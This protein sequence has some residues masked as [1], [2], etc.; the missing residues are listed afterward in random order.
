MADDLKNTNNSQENESSAFHD[1]LENSPISS[2]NISEP[3]FSSFDID[4]AIANAR[5]AAKTPSSG[6]MARRSARPKVK[7]PQSKPATFDA[8]T[9]QET[10]ESRKKA[11]T[12]YVELLNTDFLAEDAPEVEADPFKASLIVS[13]QEEETPVIPIQEEEPKKEEALFQ[14][15]EEETVQPDADEEEEDEEEEVLDPGA[16]LVDDYHYDEYEDS[17]R[18]L[19][20]DYKKIEEYLKAQSAQGYHYV[21]HEGKKYYFIKGRPHQYYYRMLYFPTAPSEE[22]LMEWSDDGWRLIYNAPSRLRK[23][24]GWFVMRNEKEEGELDKEIENEEEKQRYFRKFASSCRS[25]M[26]LLFIVMAI[27][28]VTC[29][30]QYEFKG[31]LVVMAASAVLFVIS[32]IMFIMYGRMMAKSRKQADL[33]AARVRLAKDNPEYQQ[34]RRGEESEEE[35]ESDWD[36]LDKNK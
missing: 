12:T 35:L 23:D 10:T 1:L 9:N 36:K 32:L 27:C 26:F 19:L 13:G 20:S 30:L 29:W 18:F 25:T 21:R 16:S 28:V 4:Q 6:R 15:K 5:E 24:A 8:L 14:V 22:Q 2:L 31:F 33:L 7:N 17:K 11:P 34:M 3:E